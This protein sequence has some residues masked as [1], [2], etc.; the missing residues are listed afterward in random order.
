ML[1]KMLARQEPSSVQRV[2]PIGLHQH[3]LRRRQVAEAHQDRLQTDSLK[4]LLVRSPSTR[5][6]GDQDDPPNDT[7][8]LHGE[9]TKR[10][11]PATSPTT[12]MTVGSGEV[13][14]AVITGVK[15]TIE[16]GKGIGNSADDKSASAFVPSAVL[17]V[18]NWSLHRQR[19][20]PCFRISAL[21]FQ[22]EFLQFGIDI[23]AA[24]FDWCVQGS[25]DSCLFD[26]ALTN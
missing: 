20:I 16:I 8:I 25:F 1:T 10:E 17:T 21:G 9:V 4:P 14:G 7:E 26:Q 5:H 23:P 24:C 3:R 22:L 6:K 13:A 15:N 18:V 11:V 2:E 12:G 19:R